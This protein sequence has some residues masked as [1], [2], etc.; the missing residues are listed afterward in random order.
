[1]FHRKHLPRRASSSVRE[2][3]IVLQRK[4]PRIVSLNCARSRLF[5]LWVFFSSVNMFKG[6]VSGTCFI[7]WNYK[8]RHSLPKM[9]LWDFPRELAFICSEF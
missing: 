9:D 6:Q 2:G 8:H 3:E 4:E 5:V 7:H 1:M